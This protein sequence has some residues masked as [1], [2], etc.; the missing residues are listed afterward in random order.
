MDIEVRIPPIAASNP[1][2]RSP[3]HDHLRG[4]GAASRAESRRAATLVDAGP[5]G[6]AE[7]A[8]ST[9]LGVEGDAHDESS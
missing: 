6:E 9:R 5:I 4:S 1:I 3:C 8:W 2:V 7:A